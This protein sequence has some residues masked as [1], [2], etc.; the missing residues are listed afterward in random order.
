MIGQERLFF[1]QISM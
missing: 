1:R